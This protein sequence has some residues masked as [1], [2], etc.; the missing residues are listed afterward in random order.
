MLLATLTATLAANLYIVGL[1]QL[2]DVQID[3]INKPYLPLAA[4]ALSLRAGLVVV[5]SSLLLALLL[6]LLLGRYLFLTVLIGTFIGTLYSLPPVRL[7]RYHVLAAASIFGVRGVVINLLVFLHFSTAL[8]GAPTVPAHIWAL[9]AFILVLSLVI[10]WFKDVPDMDGDRRFRIATLSLRLGARP[11]F[12]LG[13]LLLSASYLSLAL[14]ALSG[15]PAVNGPVLA[16]GHGLVLF[17][18]WLRARQVEPE[19]Q[20]SM[21][22]FYRFIWTLFYVE[23]LVF[24]LACILG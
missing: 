24:P 1:N 22:R 11:V 15:L 23:Y 7:K 18:L 12:W 10:A 5:I 21:G 19:Q 20:A 2:T 17:L 6:G 14:A 4:G 16:L 9:A 13:L 3:R 8:G